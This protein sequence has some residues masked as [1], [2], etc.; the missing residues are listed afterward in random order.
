MDLSPKELR[1]YARFEDGAAP[2][3]LNITGLKSDDAL[4]TITKAAGV[5][6]EGLTFAHGS[7]AIEIGEGA[8][9]FHR[10]PL[11]GRLL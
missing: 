2:D 8:T 10:S 5:V 3:K 7:R 4:L 1:I 11:R 6:V 9:G